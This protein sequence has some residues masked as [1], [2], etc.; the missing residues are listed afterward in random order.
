MRYKLAIFDFDGTLADSFPWFLGAVNRA[1]DRYRFRRVEEADAEMLRGHDARRVIRHV[2]MPM[3]KAP[4]VA[5]FMRAQMA[6][7]IHGIS[8]FAGVDR[9]LEELPRRGVRVAIV[10]S[11]S[12]PNIRRVLGERHAGLVGHYGC[13]ASLFG[14]RRKLRAALAA[15]G[16]RPEEAISIGDEIR[17]LVA[18]RAE[19]IPFGAVAWGYTRPESLAAL[20]PDEVF[21]RVE[22]ILERV[23]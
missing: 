10:S 14:K 8:L 19:R 12:E 20:A 11:N 17:D 4:F 21:S 3:W 9:L 15:A 2:G 5:R 23:T 18:S 13:G 7:E 22:E 6:R 1:A 16:V